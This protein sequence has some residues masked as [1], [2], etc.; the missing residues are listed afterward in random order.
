MEKEV[1][2]ELWKQ[3]IAKLPAEKS[4]F[5]EHNLSLDIPE[6]SGGYLSVLRKD[7]PS[8]SFNERS[9]M[10]ARENVHSDDFDAYKTFMNNPEQGRSPF[11]WFRLTTTGTVH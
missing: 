7:D 11:A 5:F 2:Y 8:L 4:M 10:W 3:S 6:N 9:L 1:A